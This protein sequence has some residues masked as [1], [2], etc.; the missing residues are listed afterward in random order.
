MK[1]EFLVD[2]FIVIF[3]LFLTLSFCLILYFILKIFIGSYYNF[4][5][6][7]II[8]FIIIV[9]CSVCFWLYIDDYIYNN[10]KK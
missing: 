4:I 7:K 2:L 10:L 5:L 8:T 3:E 9:L 6:F 1:N